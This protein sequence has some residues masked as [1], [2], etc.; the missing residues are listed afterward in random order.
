MSVQVQRRRG[1][2]AQHA[3][4]T[5]ALAE[6]TVDTDKKTVV[7]HDGTTAGGNPLAQ[8]A[9]PAL[10]GTPTAPTAAANT[11]TTQL[12]TTGFVLGTA[13]TYAVAQRGAVSAQGSVSGTVTLNFAAA[14]NFSLTLPAGGSIT[15][16]NPNN[17]VAGQSGVVVITQNATTVAT[18]SYGSYWKFAGGA[19]PPVTATTNAVDVLSYYV[20]SATVIIATLTK[21][22]K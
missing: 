5:G 8:A 18:V 2:T 19:A 1:T 15:L 7:V 12:A 10:T 14:N 17:L 22:L 9:S 16:A 4:F 21:D 3:T 13:N 6:L 11:S 20:A